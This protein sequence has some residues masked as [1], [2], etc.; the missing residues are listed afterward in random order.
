MP[1]VL[2][3]TL[4]ALALLAPAADA[5]TSLQKS[6]SHSMA[7]A[8]RFSGAFVIDADS[9]STLYSSRA[10]APRVLASNTKLFTSA[11]V[12][13][14]LGANST[15]A[16]TLLGAGSL[17]A[18]G[19]WKGDLYLRGG[20]DPTFGTASFTSGY[21]SQANV[22]ALAAELAQAGF[23]RVTGRVYGDESLFD[24]LRGG[25]DSGYQ[26]SPWVGPLSALDFNHAYGTRAF[27]TNPALTAAQKLKGA[28]KA[29]NVPVS[30]KAL[31]GV[32]PEGAVELAEVRSPTVTQL[33]RFQ[34]KDSD[35]FFAEML[36][37]GLAVSGQ[38]G[39]PVRSKA[40]PLPVTPT[41]NSPS[42]AAPAPAAPGPATT[43]NGAKVVIKFARTLGASPR[44]VDGSGLSRG[45]RASPRSVAT[46]LDRL[47]DRSDFSSL[48]NSLPIAG[49]DG[50]LD[51][52]MRSGPARNNCR[53]KTGT[54]TG[55]SALSGYCK[56]RA[57]S[58]VVFSI[59][60]NGVSIS[61][62][63]RLQDR[64]VQA[65]AGWRG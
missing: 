39:D 29:A 49:R 9:G 5:Q 22:E 36:E 35:N 63:H 53:A 50:T 48:Y 11:A 7:S 60:M 31:T 46:L 40:E 24:T 41:V 44:L 58:T 6:L 20:G 42:S 19:T 43:R 13:G 61:G 65:I 30:G 17:Q 26:T 59:L 55:V 3:A 21:G 12:L 51:H 27:L 52:R 56:T 1:R 62:A 33:L 64:M 57:G 15:I 8:G 4:A 25:P 47:R 28:L 54:L 2:I 23:T 18:D 32:A 34:N 10:N 38:P 16:T 45:D 14:R 37:K